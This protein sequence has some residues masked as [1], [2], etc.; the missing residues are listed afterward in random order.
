MQFWNLEATGTTS[1]NEGNSDK[2]FLTEYSRT[3]ISR[4]TDGSYCAKLPWKPIHPPLPTNSEIC[5]KRARFLVHR[6]SQTPKLL[7]TYDKIIAEQVKKGFIEMVPNTDH[8]LN[9]VHYIPHH[10]IK[11]ISTTTPIR[12]VYDCSCATNHP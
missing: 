10:C 5:W 6:L 4:Q 12:I 8:N 7:L 3:F 2:G 1:V 9:K 11:K